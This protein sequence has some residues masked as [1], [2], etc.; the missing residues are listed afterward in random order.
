MVVD[1]VAFVIDVVAVNDSTVMSVVVVF[2]LFISIQLFKMGL[3]RP[4]FLYFKSAI[5]SR[6]VSIFMVIIL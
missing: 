2:S 3:S 6:F 4:L 5:P 1:G